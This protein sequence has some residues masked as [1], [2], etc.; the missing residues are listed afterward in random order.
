MQTRFG[1]NPNINIMHQDNAHC[2]IKLN[3]NNVKHQKE[4]IQNWFSETRQR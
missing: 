1:L 2:K 3:P 4:Q